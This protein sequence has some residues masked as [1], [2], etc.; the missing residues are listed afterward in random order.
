MK[1]ITLILSAIGMLAFSSCKKQYTCICST[2]IPI[3]LPIPGATIPD[4]NYDLGK[5]TKKKAK[6]QCD[7]KNTSV[8]FFGYTLNTSCRLQ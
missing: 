5:L 6:N 2:S 7:A 8:S 1:K 4:V 3:S